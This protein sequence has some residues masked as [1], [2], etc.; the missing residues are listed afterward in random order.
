MPIINKFLC[1]L[2]LETGGLILGWIFAIISGLFAVSSV[3][4]LTI[5][6]SLHN[7]SPSSKNGVFGC[8]QSN[9]YNYLESI[10][11]SL[12]FSCNPWLYRFPALLVH[13]VLLGHSA[14][15]RHE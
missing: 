4:F 9:Q 14:Y 2:E 15:K 6:L 8:K 5:I 1:C 13:V 11:S 3:L 12:L 7:I 10:L